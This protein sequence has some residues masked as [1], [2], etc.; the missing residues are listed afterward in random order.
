MRR[1][2]FITFILPLL[3]LAQQG[4]YA[5]AAE[6]VGSTAIKKNSYTII[7]WAASCSVVR[8]YQDVSDSALGIAFVGEDDAGEGNAD[9]S[10]VCLGDGGVA[11]LV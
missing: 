5:P 7:D 2:L 8:G 1:T 3:S 9:G 4:P 11:T 6:Q 10:V